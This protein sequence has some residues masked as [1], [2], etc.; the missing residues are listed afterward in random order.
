MLVFSKTCDEKQ[1]KIK[2]TLIY[3]HEYI[4]FKSLSNIRLSFDIYED[5][6]MDLNLGNVY[7]IPFHSP[8]VRLQIKCVVINTRSN[9]FHD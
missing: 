6:S 9:V 8:T 2:C 5:V 7:L 1:K 3:G 4:Y